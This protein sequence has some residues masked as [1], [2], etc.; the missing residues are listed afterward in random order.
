MYPEWL[1]DSLQDVRVAQI[2]SQIE[3]VI[4]EATDASRQG[5]DDS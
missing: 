2:F 4:L 1:P 5:Y 3:T